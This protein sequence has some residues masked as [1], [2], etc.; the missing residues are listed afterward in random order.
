MSH[1]HVVQHH[2]HWK[3]PSFLIAERP[4]RRRVA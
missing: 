2:R 1:T 4:K 3:N